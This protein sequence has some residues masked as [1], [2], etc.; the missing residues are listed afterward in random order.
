L[1][2]TTWFKQHL[3]EQV[4]QIWKRPVLFEQVHWTWSQGI[5]VKGLQ[6]A[7]DPD[8]SHKPL[9]F[10]ERAMLTL[11]F[12]QLIRRRLVFDLEMNGLEI[13]LIRNPDGATNLEKLLSHIQGREKPKPTPASKDPQDMYLALPVD[14]QGGVKLNHISIQV[15]DR[16]QDRVLKVHNGSLLLEIPSLMEKPITLAVS[17]EEEVDGEPLPPLKLTT[18]IENLVNAK[19]ILFLKGASVDMEGILPGLQFTVRCAL[20]DMKLNGHVKLDLHPLLKA[21]RPFLPLSLPDGSGNVELFM[22]TSGVPGEMIQFDTTL[23]GRD[24]N[25]SGGALKDGHVGPVHFRAVHEGT[26]DIHKG[27]LQIQEGEIQVQNESRLSWQGTVNNLTGSAP[28]VSVSVGPVSLDSKELCSLAKAFVPVEVSGRLEMEMKASG[29]VDKEIDFDMA[30]KASDMTVS[31]GPLK[32]KVAGP[33]SFK[34][35]HK[36]RVDVG[37]GLLD[38]KAGEIQIQKNSHLVWKGVI[39]GLAGFPREVA[40]TLSPVSLDL[41]ELYGLGRKFIPL[42]IPFHFEDDP[43]RSSPVLRVKKMVLKG[44]IPQGPNR[45]EMED[46][47][48]SIPY[49]RTDTPM[50]LLSA[51]EINFRVLK[52]D[53]I[54]ESSFPVEAEILA[55]LTFSNLHLKGSEEMRMD[56]MEIYPCRVTAKNVAP[57]PEALLGIKGTITLSESGLLEG[58]VAQSRARV[59]KLE[60]TIEAECILDPGSSATVQVNRLSVSSPFLLLKGLTREPLQTGIELEAKLSHLHLRGLRPLQMDIEKLT[61]NLDAAQLFQARIEAHARDLGMESLSTKGRIDFNVR[62]LTSLIPSCVLPKGNL[63]GHMEVAWEFLGRLP[64]KEEIDSLTNGKG[65]LVERLRQVGFLE[66]FNVFTQLKD[67]RADLDLGNHSFLKVSKVNSTSPLRMSLKNGLRKGSADGKLVLGR[68]EEIPFLKKLNEPMQITLSF[69]GEQEN[70]R[71]VRFSQ[72]MQLDPFNVNQ[73]VQ[74][75]VN[76]IDSLLDNGLKSP[77]PVLMKHL[78]GSAQVTLQANLDAD[79]S[80]F[81][82]GLSLKGYLETGM[83][84]RLAEGREVTAR[85]WFESPGLDVRLGPTGHIKHLQSHLHLNKRYMMVNNKER[86][87]RQDPPLPPLSEDVLSPPTEV[88]PLTEARNSMVRRLMDDLRGRLAPRRTLS[89]DSAIIRA[90]PVHLEISNH[91]LEFRLVRDLPSVD[92][93]QMDLL[94]GTVKGSLSVSQK[95]GDFVLEANCAVSGL[96]ANRLLPHIIRG[97]PDEEAELSGKVFLWLPL[98]ADP[99]QVLRG[100]RLNVDITHI[101]SRVLERFLYALDPYESNETIVQQRKLLRVG[102]PRWISMKIQYGNLSLS[103]EVE[104]KGVRLSLPRIERFNISNLPIH[105]RIEKNLSALGVIVNVLRKMSADGIYISPDGT[106]QFVSSEHFSSLK[107]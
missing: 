59:P 54:L 46:L 17:M 70:L 9:F 52:G 30:V 96:N 57:S 77:L 90:G 32:E 103:G 37:K 50:G 80:G 60:Q 84:F 63:D 42:E 86:D 105:Q 106:V 58:F 53:V 19:E 100:L 33:I 88:K 99:H 93:F 38:I 75:F 13:Q 29:R 44:P 98:S 102:T 25:F 82:D 18:R 101:G 27:I 83:A 41:G 79:L 22:K 85:S 1:V 24:L 107:K 66:E 10:M 4:V 87:G 51:E 3:E 81:K 12:E 104:A 74:V 8:F 2:S 7:D 69:A 23:V 14:I 26:V 21:S 89:F 15:H 67:L 92:Y 35:S 95:E 20:G 65:S 78:E 47:S 62:D 31:G 72:K 73:S 16:R 40:V 36:G 11:D 94:G 28:Q 97:V 6:I 55:G 61:A 91:E 5:L 68:I 34:A 49:I 39:D 71:T 48:L 56:R 45:V 43:G 64:G 76:H